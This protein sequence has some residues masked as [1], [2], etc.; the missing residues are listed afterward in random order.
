M[1]KCRRWL[2]MLAAGIMTVGLTACSGEAKKS[3][4]TEKSGGTKVTVKFFNGNVEMVDWYNDAIEQFNQQSDSIVVEHEFLKEGTSAL[5]TKFAAGDIPDITT[6]ANQQMIDAGKFLDLS[7][8]DWWERIDPSIKEIAKDT[9]SGKNYFVPTNTVFTGIIYNKDIFNELGLT[10]PGTWS[11]FENVLRAIKEKKEEIVPLYF[12]GKEAWT[13]GMLFADIP[14]AVERQKLGII[15]YNRIAGQGEIEK[16]KM[17]EPDGPYEKYVEGLMTLQKEELINSN[18]LTATYDDQVNAMANGE[19]AM[20]FQGLFSL[21]N[22]EKNNPEMADKLGFMAFPAME[23]DVKPA[24][25]SAPDSTYYI[26]SDS[27]NQKEA[28]EFLDWLF[29]AENQKSYAETRMAPSV[30]TDVKAV[31]SPIYNGIEEELKDAAALGSVYEPVG[32]G[33][34]AIGI[35]VQE[36]FAGKYTPEEFVEAYE[37]NWKKSYEA[38]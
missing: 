37:A 26:A 20:I 12:A 35:M 13:T 28:K 29:Q 11:E 30:F 7:D 34:D 19:A 22:I 3:E 9:I 36:L 32:F 21:S 33:G 24:Y 18:V 5:Q 2:L 38:Q 15:E 8:S 16:M 31:L 1:K 17:T 23:D 6:M 25:V 14:G 10:S 27:K 4:E